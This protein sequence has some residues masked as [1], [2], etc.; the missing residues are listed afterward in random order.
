MIWAVFGSRGKT[1]IVFCIG[2]QNFSKYQEILSANL[3][4]LGPVIGERNWLFQQ[5]NASIHC[6][7]STKEWLQFNGIKVRV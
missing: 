4:P 2:N 1:E 3:V 6:S 5:D 7:K